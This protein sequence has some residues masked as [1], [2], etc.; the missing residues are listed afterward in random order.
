MFVFVYFLSSPELFVQDS[1]FVVVSKQKS[2]N[3]FLV[4]PRLSQQSCR[5]ISANNYENVVGGNFEGQN[6]CEVCFILSKT[7]CPVKLINTSLPFAHTFSP[8]Y[9]IV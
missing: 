4:V 8:V 3:T 1:E 2:K 9:D 7:V 5:K 6:Y